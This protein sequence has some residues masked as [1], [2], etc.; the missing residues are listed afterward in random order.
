MSVAILDMWEASATSAGWKKEYCE[1]S[2]VSEK[3]R[4]E[5]GKG[6]SYAL[7]E[8]VSVAHYGIEILSWVPAVSEWWMGLYN[9]IEADDVKAQLPAFQLTIE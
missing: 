7:P 8:T 2:D 4:C 5:R 6:S 3:K 9:Y 1:I